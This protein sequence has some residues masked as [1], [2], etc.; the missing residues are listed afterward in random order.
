MFRQES[1]LRSETV[2]PATVRERWMPAIRSHAPTHCITR[3]KRFV[4]LQVTARHDLRRVNFSQTLFRDN[5]PTI[6][7]AF[8]QLQQQPLRHFIHA[9]VNRTS[10]ANGVDIAKW[11]F[12]DLSI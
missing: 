8:A 12:F 7:L 5:L 2:N 4:I 1:N 6:D 3:V 11:N 10:W 9:R